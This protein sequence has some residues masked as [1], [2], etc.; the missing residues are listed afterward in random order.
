M[1][2]EDTYLESGT[3][4]VKILTF[5]GHIESMSN[6]RNEIDN[7]ASILDKIKFKQEMGLGIENTKLNA[8]TDRKL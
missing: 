6:N 3:D 1:W 7:Q 2:K 5:P 8:T 4:K